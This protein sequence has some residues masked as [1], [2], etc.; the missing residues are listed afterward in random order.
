MTPEELAFEQL[1]I[2]LEPLE[3]FDFMTGKVVL[4]PDLD[5]AVDVVVP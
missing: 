1:C 3:H 2:D 4:P 5:V